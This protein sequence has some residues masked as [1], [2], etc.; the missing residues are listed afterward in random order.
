MRKILEYCPA[1]EG[2]LVVTELSCTQ[3]ST[4]VAGQ[5]RP[6]IF[7]RL[8]AD[9]LAFLEIFVKNR[10]NVKEMERELGISYW[11]IRSRLNDVIAELGFGERPDPATENGQVERQRI[12][13]KLDSGQISVQEA[14]NML[15]GLGKEEKPDGK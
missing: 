11:S 12:L 13:E 8:S 9:S 3:C 1:C 6:T 7:S 15:A 4:R 5:F 10:G 2:E 14:A